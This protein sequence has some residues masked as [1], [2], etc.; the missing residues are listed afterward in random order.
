MRPDIQTAQSRVVQGMQLRF[1]S[2]VALSVCGSITGHAQAISTT[3]LERDTRSDRSW[4]LTYDNDFFTATDRYF[5]QG[6]HLEVVDPA[7]RRLP[8][9]ALLL[10]PTHS[11]IR[12]GIG[13]EDDG[14][15]A[16]DL[17]ASTTLRGDHPYA[18]TKQL[19]AVAI[20]T[21]TL[22]TRRY[23]SALTVGLIGQGAGG[24]E[25]QTFIHRQT[26]N[27]MPKGWHNQIRNDL[28]LNYEASVERPI[29]L[30]TR[31]IRISAIGSARVGTL[32]TAAAIGTTLIAGRSDDPFDVSHATSTHRRAFYAYLAPQAQ[33]VG[34]DATLQGGL[35]NRGSP[36]TIASVDVS[37]LVYRQRAGLVF[38]SGR[39]YIEYY[40]ALASPE[41]RGARAHRSGGIVFGMSRGN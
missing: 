12:F 24:G 26:G 11:Q 34:Y 25:I 19:R 14:Y 20:A 28:I 22:R 40:Q 41:F 30:K 32:S 23:A 15:T 16:S 17:K 4:R 39:R 1:R 8:V 36:Y 37:R 5:T 29:A 10:R 7:F 35:L 27:T 6:I 18:G 21:D 3:G 2:F 13:Y 31:G 33:L 9:A 38:R